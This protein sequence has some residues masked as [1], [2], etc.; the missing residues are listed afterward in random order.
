MRLP[1]TLHIINN[2]AS[3]CT[4]LAPLKTLLSRSMFDKVKVVIT[5]NKRKSAQPKVKE[6]KVYVG[7]LATK[8]KISFEQVQVGVEGNESHART[9]ISGA[10]ILHKNDH[11]CI[12]KLKTE[13]KGEDQS[14]G[15]VD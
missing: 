7:S 12:Y 4:H 8:C 15:D 14:K 5:R 9:K 10:R 2:E 13:L 11:V 3:N 1:T 6:A